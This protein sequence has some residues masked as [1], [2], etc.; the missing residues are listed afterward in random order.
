MIL[1]VKNLLLTAIILTLTA[2]GYTMLK[3]A[4]MPFKDVSLVSITNSTYEPKLQDRLHGILTSLLM[5]YGI[6]V[7]SQSPNK[8]SAD[9]QNYS[10]VSL[11]ERQLAASEYEV[12]ITVRFRLSN[13]TDNRSIE[14]L[15]TNPYTASF[16]A[17]RDIQSIVA[18]K[19]V[20]TDVALTN[21][22]TLFLQELAYR[23]LK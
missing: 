6:T 14:K 18:A 21:I 17:T 3:P 19:E 4:D 22:S 1:K 2:C 11:S 8:L 9:I 12:K 7:N 23:G 20:A 10:L 5:Q 15:I 13:P 16:T